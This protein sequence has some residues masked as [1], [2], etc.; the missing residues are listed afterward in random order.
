[1]AAPTP[2][3]RIRYD[4]VRVADATDDQKTPAQIVAG[5]TGG[6]V[7]QE[8]Y[9]EFVL[10]QI[11]RIIWGDDPGNWYLDFAGLGVLDLL[12]LSQLQGLRRI[13]IGLIGAINGVNLIFATPEIFVRVAG[14]DTIAVYYNGQ[15]LVETDDYA[16]S[17][18]GGIGTGYDRVTML[19]APKPGDKMTSD[20]TKKLP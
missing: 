11:K 2:Q 16:L 5:A 7:T 14:A 12:T 4:R 15:R 13:G 17:E 18:S 8:D 6:S 20:Y 19:I 1:M 3:Q 10:S 9:Q